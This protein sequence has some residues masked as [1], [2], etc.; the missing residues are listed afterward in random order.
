MKL[1]CSQAIFISS[2][3]IFHVFFSFIVKSIHT[4]ISGEPC[5]RI[6][7]LR[8]S[9]L[10]QPTKGNPRAALNIIQGEVKVNKV[11]LWWCKE[12]KGA[13]GEKG[14]NLCNRVKHKF[15]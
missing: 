9:L 5:A 12:I 2:L 15:G 1:K 10:N 11:V 6:V 13:R 8:F 14:A 3:C 7:V 4:F